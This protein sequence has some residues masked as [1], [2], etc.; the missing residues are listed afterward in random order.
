MVEKSTFA[1]LHHIGVVVSD[2]D[3]AIQ[4][5]EELGIGPFKSMKL[6]GTITE[7]T[8]LGKNMDYQIRSA[9]V[10]LG[11][12]EIE[13]I[14][15]VENALLQE[16]FLAKHGEG[17]NHIAFKVENFDKER[18]KLEKKGLKIVM[19]RNRSSG[20]KAAYFDATEVGGVIF[21]VFQPQTEP[22][23]N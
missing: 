22:K 13:L 6:P 16:E 4:Y 20:I 7:Q 5:Y 3:K 23:S 14:Q 11:P 10:R 12:I 15:P 2:L 17:I 19:Y 8:M 9:S 21:E 18:A 1:N